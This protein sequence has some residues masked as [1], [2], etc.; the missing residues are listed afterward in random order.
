MLS[1]KKKII[2]KVQMRSKDLRDSE[3]RGV[4]AGKRA[5]CS[6]QSVFSKARLQ[7]VACAFG[8]HTRTS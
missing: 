4:R 3:L 8:G 5:V 2:R 7:L 1:A 6:L